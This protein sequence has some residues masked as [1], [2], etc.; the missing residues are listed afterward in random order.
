MVRKDLVSLQAESAELRRQLLAQGSP[1]IRPALGFSGLFL[2]S[3][4]ALAWLRPQW[5]SYA[6]M[7]AALMIA[8]VWLVYLWRAGLRR[9]ER[10]RLKGQAQVLE[11]RREKAQGKLA[12]LDERF[13]RIGMSPSAVEI[14]KMQKNLDRHRQ[15][16]QQ[17]LE[18]ESALS[19]LETLEGKDESE[20][21]GRAGGR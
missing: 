9:A 15:L 5:M 18:V 7:G 8:P 17:L 3:G 13:E 2:A 4:A 12:E 20:Q 21:G 16:S 1:P 6:L 14:V 19:V 11:G 10:G